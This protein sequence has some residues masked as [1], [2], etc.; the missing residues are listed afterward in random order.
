ME[1]G[2]DAAQLTRIRAAEARIPYAYVAGTFEVPR[3]WARST[4]GAYVSFGDG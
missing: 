1:L 3:G 2:L 4:P